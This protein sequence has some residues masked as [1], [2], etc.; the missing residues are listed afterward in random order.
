VLSQIRAWLGA[1]IRTHVVGLPGAAAAAALLNSMAE[2]GGTEQYIDTREPDE[3][4]TRLSAIVESTVRKGWDSCS[5]RLDPVTDLPERLQLVVTQQGRERTLAADGSQ[6]RVSD[7]GDEVT[8]Q[9]TLC[10]QATS[11]AIEAL[12]FDYG[13]PDP[14]PELF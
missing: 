2:A 14:E 4:T 12:R 7:A 1:G 8:L 11:G 5:F 13:C 9:G 3:L 10:Q 6:F